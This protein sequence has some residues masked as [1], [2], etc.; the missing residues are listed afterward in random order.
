MLYVLS[1]LRIII[2]TVIIAVASVQCALQ[3]VGGVFIALAAYMS[4]N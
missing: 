2:N 3:K 1:Y 4:R